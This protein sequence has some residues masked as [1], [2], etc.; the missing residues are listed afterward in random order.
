MYWSS[1]DAPFRAS[2]DLS[3][4]LIVNDSFR[5]TGVIPAASAYDNFPGLASAPALSPNQFIIF[6]S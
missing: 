2:S 3:P 5:V 4:R 1:H 6:A